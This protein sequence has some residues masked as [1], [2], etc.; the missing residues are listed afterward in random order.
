MLAADDTLAANQASSTPSTASWMRNKRFEVGLIAITDVQVEI[1]RGFGSGRRD[2]R[3]A[4]PRDLQYML[5]ITGQQYKLYD[6][7]TDM[8]LE[9]CRSPRQEQFGQRLLEQNPNLISS[10]LAADVARDNVA[11]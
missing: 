4:R 1:A 5:A 10:R 3:Q 8:P 7:G 6:P 9:G 11:R 2:R